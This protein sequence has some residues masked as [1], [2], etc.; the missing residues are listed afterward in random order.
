MFF[1]YQKAKTQLPLKV[2]LYKL[3]NINKISL[4]KKRVI[5]IFTLGDNVKYKIFKRNNKYLRTHLHPT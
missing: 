3:F 1:F 5:F 2:Y 4:L